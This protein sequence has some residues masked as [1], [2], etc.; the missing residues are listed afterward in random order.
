M[1]ELFCFA[2]E[3]LAFV[4]LT[5]TCHLFITGDVFG[6]SL[7]AIP[8]TIHFVWGLKGIW[9]C[10]WCGCP[11]PWDLSPTSL[12]LQGVVAQQAHWDLPPTSL[13]FW[14]VASL[15]IGAGAD[16]QRLGFCRARR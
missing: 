10:I 13:T 9:T 16:A 6:D 2:N 12:T 1:L 11:A 8:L 5:H 4:G 14:S 3:F 7:F 15:S